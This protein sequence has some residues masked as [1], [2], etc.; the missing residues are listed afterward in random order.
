MQ[1]HAT[2]ILSVRHRNFVALGGDGQVTL[3]KTI[4]KSDACKVRKL[5]GGNVIVGFAGGAADAFALME[6]FEARLEG[7]SRQLATCGYGTGERLAKRSRAA[8]FGSA[9][10]RGRFAAQFVDQ[11]DG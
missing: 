7:L 5:S 1:F 11:R 6:R 8:T 2:T 9:A 10:D 4:V 3:D